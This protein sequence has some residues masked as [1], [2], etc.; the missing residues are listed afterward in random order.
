LFGIRIAV[1][2]QFSRPE[3][4]FTRLKVNTHSSVRILWANNKNS[5][6]CG[7]SRVLPFQRN[8]LYTP[9]KSEII[10][11]PRGFATTNNNNNN[12]VTATTTKSAAATIRT[13]GRFCNSVA[14]AA[15]DLGR[16]ES[17]SPPAASTAAWRPPRARASYQPTGPVYPQREVCVY[18]EV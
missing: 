12:N 6:W 4:K 18:K 15:D 8:A 3:R 10:T 14:A 16:A 13:C 1:V 17:P 9:R 11:I 2:R 5:R 7:A